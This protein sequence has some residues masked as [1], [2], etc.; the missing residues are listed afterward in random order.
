[1]TAI[2]DLFLDP[3]A[4]YLSS[5][6]LFSQ[7]IV[8]PFL[9]RI[10][11][12]TG[13][14]SVRILGGR[15]CGKTM[16]I[17]YFSHGS[18]LNAKR[19][20]I[21]ESELKSVGLYIR[22]DTG[23]CGLM[24][25]AWLGE[26]P[27]K[28]AFSH[29]VALNLL[30]D[31][32]Q[33]VESIRSANFV[34]GRIDVGDPQLSV[35]LCKQLGVEDRRVSALED[36]MDLRLVDLEDWVRNPK[37]APQP[38]FIDFASALPRFARDLA[39]STQ[40]LAELEFR[41]FIDEF[42]NLPSPHR[43]VI[44]DAIKHPSDRLVV[45]IAHK[46]QAV[47]DFK[48]SSDERVVE[49]HD[50]RTIDLEEQ[51]SYK[52]G[53]FELL[54]AELFLLRVHQAEAQFDCPLFKPEQLHDPK[55]LKQR[56]S[57]P[58][59]DQVLRCVREI[60]PSPSAASIAADALKDPVLK[61]RLRDMIQKGLVL[62]KLTKKVTADELIDDAHPEVSIVMGALLNRRSQIGKDLLDQ[63]HAAIKSPS[64]ADA[65]HK[66]GGWI[67]N[68]L[69]GCLFHLY[70][71]LPRRANINYAGFDR[72]CMM[73]DPNLRFFQALCHATLAL[74]FKRQGGKDVSGPLRV[75]IDTQANAAKQ[76]SDK[77]FQD[78]LQLGG[79]GNQLLEITGRLGRVFE[80]FNR[81]RSQSEPEVN[82][83]SID[84]ADWAKLS[85][86]ANLLLREAK[87]WSVLYEAKDTKNK[88]DYDIAQTDLILNPIYAPHF[89]ISYRK[90]RKVTLHPSQA[91]VLLCQSTES[92]EVVLKQLVDPNE[93]DT[94]EPPQELF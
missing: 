89:S 70:A 84:N 54:A 8:P 51:L 11:T 81:R 5:D 29:Y 1:M 60:L 57:K 28:L 85:D 58:Y 48:T 83:L 37:H 39:A 44:C 20:D 23:F 73:A 94:A 72:F 15:G 41:A 59:R 6:S 17:R 19:V 16:F 7:F 25:A 42:E 34:G 21:L 9:E 45:N 33:A 75:D 71:G 36:V 2:A 31:A 76:V 10:P 92:Y 49:G 47:V 12:F 63:Y 32:C 79:H 61:K 93:L 52:T 77:L 87:I 35:A 64:P 26:Q 4:D 86:K 68:N 27:A 69:H 91:D 40:R 53:E 78:I 66:V 56:L 82:H 65:F 38:K 13:K 46:K 30:K 18:S 50:L 24:S 80:A 90:R 67:D 22:P 14:G 43:E 88:S 3:R 55:Y 74:A 62:Q